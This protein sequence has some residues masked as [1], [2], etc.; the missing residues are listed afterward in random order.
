MKSKE[1]MKSPKER[2][3]KSS[4]AKSYSIRGRGAAGQ[5][6]GTWNKDEFGKRGEHNVSHAEDLKSNFTEKSSKARLE[7]DH[8]MW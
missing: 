6:R 4:A 8:W 7:T 5:D 3:C 2:V 1:W